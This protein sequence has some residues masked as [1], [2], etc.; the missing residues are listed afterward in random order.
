M[1]ARPGSRY[2]QRNHPQYPLK[3]RMGEPHVQL[4]RYGA[5]SLASFGY[6]P[7]I[8][9]SPSPSLVTILTTFRL[10]LGFRTPTPH[11]SKSGACHLRTESRGTTASFR[12]SDVTYLALQRSAR[13]TRPRKKRPLGLCRVVT[14]VFEFKLQNGDVRICCLLSVVICDYYTYS[15]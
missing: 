3:T 1:T 6:R 8:R 11:T 15:G 14:M 12:T 9:W 2:P 5:N 10:T 7:T 4:R 13:K